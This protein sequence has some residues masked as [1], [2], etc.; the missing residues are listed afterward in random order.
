MHPSALNS[1]FPEEAPLH[2][3][4]MQTVVVVG[5]LFFFL[6]GVF[7]S[8]A[9]TVVSSCWSCGDPVSGLMEF[10]ESVFRS[11][12]RTE[13][14]YCNELRGSLGVCVCVCGQGCCPLLSEGS[15][16]SKPGESGGALAAKHPHR[17]PLVPI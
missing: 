13:G 1:I 6:L 12:I 5:F 8:T 7:V 15:T 3:C 4:V 11:R 9:L 17:A 2:V 14:D 10:E 16:A